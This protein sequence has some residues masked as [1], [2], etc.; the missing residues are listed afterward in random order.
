MEK[1][2]QHT[3]VFPRAFSEI[4]LLKVNWVNL[5]QVEVQAGAP[6]SRPCLLL[7]LLLTD[8]NQLTFAANSDRG[9]TA[10]NIRASWTDVLGPLLLDEK[11]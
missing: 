3:S 8:D 2:T 9:T 5:F 6:R 4:L 11:R 1:G 7:L 10:N